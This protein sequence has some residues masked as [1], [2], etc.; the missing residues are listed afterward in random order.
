MKPEQKGTTVMPQYDEN[1]STY[2][3]LVM[4][5]LDQQDK[6]LEQLEGK[7][8]QIHT[9]V[10]SFKSTA[11]FTGAVAGFTVSLLSLLLNYFRPGQPQ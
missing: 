4:F 10:V 11:R 2:E 1:W 3:K 9:D 5:R 8:N 7:T 6:K